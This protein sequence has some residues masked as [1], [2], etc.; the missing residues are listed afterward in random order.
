MGRDDEPERSPHAADLLDR[1]GVGERVEARTALV[2]RDGDAQPAHLAEALHDVDGEFS[3]ALV[4]VDDRCDFL[5]HELADRVAEEDV[6]GREVE[7]HRGRAY[8]RGRQGQSGPSGPVLAFRA[9]PGPSQAPLRTRRSYRAP[10]PPP[11]PPSWALRPRASDGRSSSGF[12]TTD[13]AL[14]SSHGAGG[15][16][17]LDAE[18]ASQGLAERRL[19]LG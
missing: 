1:D 17:W 5:R 13:P 19:L 4:L 14:R 3:L 10:T 8:H 15:R 7:V 6:L 11:L 9:C 12:G 16:R 18:L 2:L